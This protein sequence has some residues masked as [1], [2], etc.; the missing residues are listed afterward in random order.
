M[1]PA[2]FA[3]LGAAPII[4]S[5]LY[6]V[7]IVPSKRSAAVAAAVLPPIIRGER[8]VLGRILVAVVED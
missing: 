5:L 2:V 3:Q 4:M 6:G 7:S 1:A 8:L